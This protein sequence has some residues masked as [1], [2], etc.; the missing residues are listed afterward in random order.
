[1]KRKHVMA[2]CIAALVLAGMT[3]ITVLVQAQTSDP[4][5]VLDGAA[6]QFSFQNVTAYE[7]NTYPN[8]FKD[9][10][11]TAMM[12]GD[13]AGEEIVVKVENLNS[14]YADIY[15]S[16]ESMNGDITAQEAADYVTLIGSGDGQDRNKADLTVTW[17]GHNGAVRHRDL[18]NGR[19]HLGTFR[20]GDSI[21]IRVDI[22]IPIEAGNELQNLRAEVGWVFQGE[23]FDNGSGG[24][25][26]GGGG[27]GSGSIGEVEQPPVEFAGPELNMKDH[28]AYIIGRTDGLVHPEANITRAEVAAVF[29]RLLTDESRAYYWAETNP[30]Y[31]VYADDWCNNEISTLTRAGILKGRLDGNYDPTASITRA[32]FAVL[33]SR[34]FVEDDRG[35]TFS[36]I[37][38]H[39]AQ[40]EIESVC[41]KGFLQGYPGGTFRPNKPITRAELVTIMNRL[42]GRAPHKDHLLPDMILWPDNMDTNAW[43]YADMQEATNSHLRSRE[44]GAAYEEW[45]EILP[46]PDWNALEEEW[47]RLYT[48]AAPDQVVDSRTN[49]NYR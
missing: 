14:G 13:M 38:G 4:T 31:D 49:A 46:P 30:Y 29:F 2:A 10:T 22:G 27:A 15:L 3:A 25:S 28:F 6:R 19:V 18:S 33:C 34:F 37:E 39:W 26:G 47:S 12:P 8:L 23:I 17:T 40:K 44:E 35:K 16:A 1:M 43:Y 36:D 5:V 24:G 45:E 21:T 48:S 20:E 42:L 7:G 41:A 9:T 11:F 32:E